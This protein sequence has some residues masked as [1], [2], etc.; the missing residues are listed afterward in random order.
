MIRGAIFSTMLLGFATFANA[1][2]PGRHN[3]VHAILQRDDS[4]N[5][6]A[7]ADICA[8]EA[9]DDY[10]LPIHIA[11]IFILFA[12][13]SLGIYG[14]IALGS[15]KLQNNPNVL[16]LLQI[17]KFFGA[18]VIVA[19]AW[20][21][22]LPGAFGQFTSPCLEGWWTIYGGN[23]VGAFGLL[24]AF[25]VQL[26]ELTRLFFT[27]Q[28]VAISKQDKRIKDQHSHKAID[29]ETQ[30]TTRLHVSDQLVADVKLV[31]VTGHVHGEEIVLRDL[32]TVL[33]EAGIIFHSVIIGLA[34]GTATSEFNTLLIALAF[35]QMFEGMALGTR[36][37]ELQ[38]SFWRKVF[39]YGIAYP[40]TTPLGTAIG[41][42]IRSTFNENSQAI[43]LTQGIFDSLS[44]GVLIYNVYVELISVEMNHN[45]VFRQQ[46]TLRK[47]IMFAN[48]SRKPL[49]DK[50]LIAN[51]GEIACRVER[52][53]VKLGIKTVAVYSEADKNAMHV[54]MADEAYLIGPPP[55]SESYLRADKIIQIAKDSGAQAIHP[56][57][58]FLSENA[59]FA[60]QVTKAGLTFIGPPVDA[61]IAMGSKS[62]SKI[63]MTNAGVPVVPGYHGEEQG[64]DYLKKQADVIG[65]P[66]LI[67]AIMGG[68]G[69][70]MRI[71]DKPEDFEAMLESSRREAQKSFGDTKVLVEKYLVRPRHVE[72]QVFADKLGNAV[73]LFERDC[74]V[75]RRH[76]K[77]LEEAPA[78][79]L[80]QALREDLG[81]KAVAAA[82]A[83]KYVGAGTVEFILDTTT[84]KFYFM[85]MNTRL[86]VEHPVTEMVTGT[87]LVHW[88]LEVAAG[89]PLPLLQHQLALNGHAFEA[90]IYAE[91]PNNNFLPDTGPLLHLKTPVASPSIRIETGV[92]EGDAVSV[93]YDP[94]ISKLVVHGEDRTAA[95]RVLR[96]ALGEFEVVGLKTNIEF[97]KAL[98]GNQGFV[99][100]D[101]ETG[102]IKKREA[103]L[104][105]PPSPLP[106]LVIA[107]AALSILIK[108]L[109]ASQKEARLSQDY[110]SPWNQIAFR[111][112]HAM[113][114]TIT[115]IDNSK[116]CNVV[117]EY[118]SPDTLS[119]T[120][121]DGTGAVTRYDSVTLNWKGMD[122][123]SS[124]DAIEVVADVGGRKVRGNVVWE[125]NIDGETCHV[126]QDGVN[127]TI[128]K[129]LPTYLTHA[130]S[131]GGASD[132]RTPMPC[133]ISSV[134]VKVGQKVE[135]GQT[136]VILEA[137][138]MEHVMKA[139]EAGVIKKVHYSVGDL[140]AEKKLLI[141]FE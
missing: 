73:Y 24:A 109:R 137:M 14:T 23:W 62:A 83:V 71:V 34:L 103:D 95:L 97:L 119:M 78:P 120:V 66:V 29:I 35:H 20:I 121:T 136:L 129:P 54:Q 53:A 25:I 51:R 81:N 12:V 49:F 92:R 90:R 89:N 42:G 86:Q 44:A 33:L 125:R 52:T 16:L 82:R 55:S 3:H 61:I 131:I 32:S 94:M 101:V 134:S 96:K 6:S 126:F 36:I 91:N 105:P 87:D 50:I 80:T 76:Q 93:Y 7:V 39:V 45:S 64:V 98:A 110:Y 88:Q 74:S 17:I 108:Q 130:A 127:Y 26:V 68:G 112:N 107:Q 70:G 65:Y 4:S 5:I 19:T 40:L 59:T 99:D 27:T 28:F 115:F 63:I 30:S 43:I 123:F 113:S 41:I 85:E 135:K 138:K 48:A 140:V 58:G 67:K 141:S 47:S 128:T 77:I 10:D 60:D 111:L 21:H 139:P 31:D 18:G 84:N 56:G 57:Y 8:A 38:T 102:F 11:G 37:A 46:S 104:F 69:K 100:A 122:V 116:T 15:S 13:S 106:P 2:S 124:S 114:T 9:S 118:I 75:Q 1:H 22:M 133:K 132:V 72:V 117:V 79:G